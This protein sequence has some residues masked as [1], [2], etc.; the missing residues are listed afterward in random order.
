MRPHIVT[1]SLDSL[2]K[3]NTCH[4]FFFYLIIYPF[5]YW[6]VCNN[7]ILINALPIDST[8]IILLQIE[9]GQLLS[10]II[11]S[12]IFLLARFCLQLLLHQHP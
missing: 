3:L 9:T 5:P 7:A 1:D 8:I 10:L 4:Y 11:F 6:D 2:K 12:N